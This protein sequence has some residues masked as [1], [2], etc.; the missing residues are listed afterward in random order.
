MNAD[1]QRR[2][3]LMGGLGIVL[4]LGMSL[5]LIWLFRN[6]EAEFVS[7]EKLRRNQE[8]L[9]EAQRLARVGSWELDLVSGKL[10]WSDEL[11]H[12]LSV[13]RHHQLSAMNFF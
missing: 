12:I 9:R 2:A 7:A 13:T 6:Q 1:W 10:A 5:V 4:F 11:F 3:I 8:Q